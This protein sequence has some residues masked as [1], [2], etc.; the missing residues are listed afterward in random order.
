MKKR[1]NSLSDARS[2]SKP[3]AVR[4]TE[5]EAFLVRHQ[6]LLRKLKELKVVEPPLSAHAAECRG[7][8]TDR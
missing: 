2:S 7:G 5:L 3:S 6:T 4:R 1:W 8:L